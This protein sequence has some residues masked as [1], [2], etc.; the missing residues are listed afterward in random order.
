MVLLIVVLLLGAM[1]MM[2]W[3]TPLPTARAA[4]DAGHLSQT[5]EYFDP[6]AD[7]YVSEVA[8]STNFGS[9]TKLDVQNLDGGEFPDD[10]RSYVGF[11]LSSIPSNAIITSA[12][13]KA[14]L[15]DASG[16]SS[17]YIQLRRVTSSWAYNTVTWNNKPS[18]SSYTGMYVDTT[19]GMRGW[20]VTSLVQD[21][22]I[23]R[24]FGTSPNFGLEL[25]GPESGSYYLRSFYSANAKSNKPY[26]V[27]SYELPTP[28]PTPTRTR[29]PTRTHTPTVTNTP[30]PTKTPTF[31]VT[32][33][34]TR[35]PTLTHTPT[36]MPTA[37][38]TPTYT[39]T[40]PPTYT[41]THTPTATATPTQTPTRT[42]TPTTTPTLTGQACPDPYEP[43]DNFDQAWFLSSGV[44]I[45]SYICDG[46]DLDYFKFAA[47]A[48]DQIRLELYNLPANY[49]LCLYDPG[50]Q[51]LACS[52]NGGTNA[53]TIERTAGSSG[54]HYALVYGAQGAYSP[55]NSYTFRPEVKAP[56][57]TFTPTRTP[58]HT[59]TRT[60]TRTPT[61]TSIATP[62]A[63]PIC[64]DL[65]EPNETFASASP[66]SA[67]EY[68]AYICAPGDQDWFSINLVP[69]Q[70]LQVTLN[71]PSSAKQVS[72][73]D[74]PKNY[75]L[76]LYDPLGRLVASSHNGG[77]APESIGFTASA[78]GGA[79][80]IRVFGV[81]GDFDPDNPYALKLELGIAPP[82][83]TPTAT[84]THTPVPSCG[85]DPYEANNSSATAATIATGTEIHA[86][87][88]PAMDSDYYRFPVAGPVEI[89]ARL[90]DLP[91]AYELTLFDPSGWVVARGSGS[92][93][94]PRELTYLPATDGDYVVRIGPS[95]PTSWDEDSPYSL[96]AVSYTHLTLPT[97]YSV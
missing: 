78:M 27:V 57:P 91:A 92:G 93:T 71:G 87:I 8:P 61:Q 32:P 67:G 19:T 73:T 1:S 54:D 95:S 96:Q 65:Y 94:S 12:A 97:I 46:G 80:R 84:P 28:T 21:Y 36:K 24:N 83:P 39:P 13:F 3:S 26:L 48:G 59:P 88:C 45:Q 47:N 41:P 74:L 2:A 72:L 82:T 60:P 35:T 56:T 43:N 77:T 38:P 89:H 42:P 63:T 22:W 23:N 86:Y 76:E 68:E 90:Y 20:D 85:P 37:T 79:Y 30:P 40:P 44:A 9:A 55:D 5:T 16:L 7:A 51:Q 66:L 14:Y 69:H 50:R 49:D 34:P 52:T 81:G 15:Y 11:N 58:T 70:D 53:E 25:R 4:P 18:S 31:T 17:V 62:T 33:T 6:V 10:R 29:T 75:D 64:P